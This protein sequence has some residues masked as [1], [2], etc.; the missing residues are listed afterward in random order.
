MSGEEGKKTSKK[1][2]D[3][4]SFLLRFYDFCV[5]FAPYIVIYILGKLYVGPVVVFTYFII[6]L[7]IRSL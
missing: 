2:M 5:I 3:Y 6:L 1:E 7:R 4:S